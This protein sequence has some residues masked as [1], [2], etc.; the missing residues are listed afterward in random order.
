LWDASRCWRDTVQIEASK[1]VV[2]LC[3]WSFT[4]VNLN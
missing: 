1:F 4:L 2:V 3:H